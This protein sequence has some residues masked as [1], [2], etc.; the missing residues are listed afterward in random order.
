MK[1]ILFKKIIRFQ[2]QNSLVIYK[3]S[4]QILYSQYHK[5]F[6]N[7]L[8]S[9]QIFYNKKVRIQLKKCKSWEYKYN[10]CK[11]KSKSDKTQLHKIWYNSIL[12][13]TLNK[14]KKK[15]K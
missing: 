6:K 3:E 7:I 12:M 4:V 10:L 13:K 8:K 2:D 5:H 11:F 15:Q 1:E 9:K 14:I